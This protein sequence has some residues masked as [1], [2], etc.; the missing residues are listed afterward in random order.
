MSTQARP[1][2]RTGLAGPVIVSGI[3]GSAGGI[4]PIPAGTTHGDCYVIG[5]AVTFG[6][7]FTPTDAT[8]GLLPEGSV[9]KAYG[10]ELEQI[11]F[12]RA[13]GEAGS[14]TVR[15]LFYKEG[16]EKVYE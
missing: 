11:K 4:S 6:A 9:Y 5:G 2:G 13:S 16:V 10:K 8:G 14:P 15:V 12:I 7:G 1:F 3:D